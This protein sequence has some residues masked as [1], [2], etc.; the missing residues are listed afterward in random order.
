METL[1]LVLIAI[2]LMTF[3]VL[4]LATQILFKKEGKFPNYHIGGNKHM[5]ERGVSCAQSY[6]KI[7]QAKARKELRFK[8]IALD[9]TETE[10]YC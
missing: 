10:S 2:G 3:V 6:D 4:G 9:E 8:Q 1:K 7:E 5:K